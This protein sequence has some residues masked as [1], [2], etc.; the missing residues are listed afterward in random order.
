M[1]IARLSNHFNLHSWKCSKGYSNSLLIKRLNFSSS[2]F[3]AMFGGK[4]LTIED[5]QLQARPLSRCHRAIAALI[6]VIIFPIFL[7]GMTAFAIKVIVAKVSNL[8][9]KVIGS[10]VNSSSEDAGLRE[11]FAE[12]SGSSSKNNTNGDAEILSKK[13]QM[14]RPVAFEKNKDIDDL[15]EFLQ[16]LR[17]KLEKESQDLKDEAKNKIE[18][19]LHTLICYIGAGR[20]GYLNKEKFDLAKLKGIC[21]NLED[22]VE[23]D[24]VPSLLEK[25]KNSFSNKAVF[26]G[27][28]MLYKALQ[29][30]IANLSKI[31]KLTGDDLCLKYDYFFLLKPLLV[32][33]T[34]KKNIKGLLQDK[35]ELLSKKLANFDFAEPQLTVNAKNRYSNAHQ[36]LQAIVG[37][38]F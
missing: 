23:K 26:K 12:K 30:Y 33:D 13:A 34:T 21:A 16:N 22:S 28:I 4:K 1:D 15:I 24:S 29:I 7:F 37:S 14:K 32:Q 11:N 35:C 19:Q 25:L 36:E 2:L 31:G 20:A 27:P 3:R 9:E 17:K 5:G 6:Q 8:K 18:M 10:C 38:H